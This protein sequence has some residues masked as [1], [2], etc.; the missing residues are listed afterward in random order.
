MP[1]KGF[2]LN[3]LL[4]TCNK[5]LNVTVLLN[6]DKF[7]SPVTSELVGGILWASTT[8]TSL[9]WCYYLCYVSGLCIAAGAGTL[10]YIRRQTVLKQ[11]HNGPA[12]V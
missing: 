2:V 6:V 10:V 3:T 7:L 12:I 5:V 8:N 4:V 1:I 11:L 9:S